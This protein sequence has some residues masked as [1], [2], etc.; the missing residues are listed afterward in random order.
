M[1]K[2]IIIVFVFF[3]FYSYEKPKDESGPNYNVVVLAES[4]S[5]EDAFIIKFDSN[6]TG[7]FNNY[8]DNS[9][10]AINLAEEFKETGTK[11]MVTFRV[12]TA[13][14]LIE[15]ENSL[16]VYPQIYIVSAHD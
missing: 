10:V 3:L 4:S 11:L 2:V 6:V 7:L 16:I 12:P 1:K 9:Y 8:Q 5:C 15:C 14:E 13:E